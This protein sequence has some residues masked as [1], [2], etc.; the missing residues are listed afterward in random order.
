MMYNYN[1]QTGL[2]KLIS[3]PYKTSYFSKLLLRVM[4][5][6]EGVKN[7]KTIKIQKGINDK[8]YI[9]GDINFNISHSNNMILCCVD[10]NNNLGVDIEK[11]KEIPKDIF[12]MVFHKNEL[13]YYKNMTQE[14]FYKIWT[15]KEAYSKYTSLGL[16]EDFL[17]IDTT[18]FNFEKKVIQWTEEDYICSIYANIKTKMNIT[19][20]TESEILKHYD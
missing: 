4:L 12:D 18:A 11:I 10:K 7:W 1:M 15:L 6:E 17:K 14:Q 8:P 5:K 9:D 2:L 16:S 13:K 19:R 20:Y 3:Q